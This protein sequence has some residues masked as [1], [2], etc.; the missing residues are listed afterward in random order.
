MQ[1]SQSGDEP[2]LMRIETNAGHGAGKPTSKQVEEVVD[3]WSFLVRELEMKIPEWLTRLRLRLFF[4]SLRHDRAGAFAAEDLAEK[5]PVFAD[6][7]VGQL[8]EPDH[9]REPE[10]QRYRNQ[11][12]HSHAHEPD[13]PSATVDP[14]VGREAMNR[15]H[16]IFTL[17]I[18]S[19]LSCFGI[20]D[21]EKSHF[22]E[23]VQPRQ[24]YHLKRT[25]RALAVVED[26]VP[27]F[28]LIGAFSHGGEVRRGC[29]PRQSGKTK[30]AQQPERGK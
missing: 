29:E 10:N 22:L 14:A 9:A 12:G 2:I 24:R 30:F 23:P 20:F 11:Q 15:F 28:D 5:Q 16:Q 6:E 25:H 19:Q 8:R 18:R 4:F 21:R 3:R 26:N 27:G 1:P 7:F 13:R 17:Q